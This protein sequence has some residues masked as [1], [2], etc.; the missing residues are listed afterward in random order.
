MNLHAENAKQPLSCEAAL[1]VEGDVKIYRPSVS[2]PY[3]NLPVHV[4]GDV[5][6]V[7]ALIVAQ[8]FQSTPSVGRATTMVFLFDCDND[9]SIHALR[10]EGDYLCRAVPCDIFK[11]SIH[12]LRGEGD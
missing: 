3:F 12:A 6:L 4:Q 2:P 9:I 1:L 5:R 8:A 11:I 10:G 7:R